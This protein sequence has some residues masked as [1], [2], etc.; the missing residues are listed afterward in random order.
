MHQDLTNG[1]IKQ[2]IKSIGIP[3]S[4][5][6]F[7][8]T[9]F[10]ITDMY[11]AGHLGSSA[12]ASLALCGVVFFTIISVA[13][14]LSKGATALVGN[15]IGEEDI[16]KAQS[17]IVNSFYLATFL[18]LFLYIF[19]YFYM[20]V[21]FTFTNANGEYLKNALLYI[22]VI[23]YGVG[24]YIFTF[25]SNSILIALGDSKSFRNVLVLN[26][27]LNIILTSWFVLGGFGLESMGIEGIALATVIV[28]FFAMSFLL[29]KISTLKIS[30]NISSYKIDFKI[31]YDL[32]I[33][34]LPTTANNLLMSS[35]A[36]TLMYFL[37]SLGEHYVSAYGIGIRIEQIALLPGIG[38]SVA[39]AAMVSQNN[40]AKNYRR[41]KDIMSQ[42][43]KFVV[44]IFLFGFVF[45]YFLASYLASYF[46]ND[47][48][49][50]NEASIYIKINAVLLYAY[51]IIFINVSFLQAIKRPKM[52][53]YIGLLR[54]VILPIILYSLASYYDMDV[55]YYWMATF[56]SVSVATVYIHYLQKQY[57]KEMLYESIS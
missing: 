23:F 37:S 55:M 34:G 57:L 42:T 4:V 7:F 11:Y 17:T 2:Q 52:I 45:M 32:F 53:F 29:Y 5:G 9:M 21:I 50:L 14:G 18:S 33:Q 25:F 27:F 35:G 22:N 26:F 51:I 49:I 39:I 48:N 10:N 3:A 28:E 6:F 47:I 19:A 12:I 38:L 36:F 54:Q 56:I 13:S 46:T 41:I 40:G 44:F 16:K 15:A 30:Q 20:E 1:N 24:F 8:Y 31:L 43:Y